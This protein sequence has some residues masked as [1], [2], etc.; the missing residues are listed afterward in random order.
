M[1]LA[2]EAVISLLIYVSSALS[3]ALYLSGKGKTCY[4]K[5]EKTVLTTE[6]QWLLYLAVA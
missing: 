5:M 3:I 6:R 2:F 1:T 4:N